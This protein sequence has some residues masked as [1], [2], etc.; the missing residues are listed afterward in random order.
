[1][2][3]VQ[4]SRITNRKGL[5]ENLPQLAGAELGW[6]I[7]ERRLF[8]G[9]GTLAEG[10]P[11][12]GNTELLTE[13]SDILAEQSNYSYKGLAAGYQATTGPN[14]TNVVLSLQNWL[15]QFATVKDFGAV[16]DGVTDDTDAINRALFQLYCREINPQVRRSLFFPAGRYLVSDVIKIPTYAKLVGEGANS[17]VIVLGTSASQ[18]VACYA[19]SLQQTGVN[20]GNNGAIAPTNIEIS[21]MG[22]HT[23]LQTADVFLVED[24]TFCSFTDVSFAGPFLIT[25]YFPTPTA[26]IAADIAAIRFSAEDALPIRDVVFKRCEFTALTYA[27]S[28]NSHTHGV[29]FTDSKFDLLYQGIVLSNPGS[30]LPGSHG[31]R[32]LSNSFDQIHQEAIIV[33]VNQELVT[34]GYNIFYDCG[35]GLS[36]PRVPAT[37]VIDFRESNNVSLA[38]MF[39]RTDLEALV[40][41][42]IRI[43][44]NASIAMTN[45]KEIQMGTFTRQSGLQQTLVAGASGTLLFEV[46]ATVIPAFRLDYTIIRD[47]S[48]SSDRYVRTGTF[49]V[50]SSSD[51][52]G[53]DLS[54]GDIGVENTSPDFALTAGESSSVV[55]VQYTDSSVDPAALDGI[56]KYSMTYLG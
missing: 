7:D 4:V 16:G 8:I 3:I 29:V 2:A 48:G 26:P 17:S 43:G 19:D 51:G 31:M 56:I 47:D 30:G 13:F 38:D 25:D 53:S 23:T 44:T 20:I 18:H 10:A 37:P 28:T 11:T 49:T 35:N 34:T 5:A 45:G 50:V 36:S 55:Q 54:I 14:N 24:G 15:D 21:S 6:A 39:E 42:R 32:I 52:T 41:E 1:M 12:V 46:D 40:R 27:V 9:N 33:D 22:F